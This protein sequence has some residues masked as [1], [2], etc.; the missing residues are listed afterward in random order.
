MIKIKVHFRENVYE[1]TCVDK[2]ELDTVLDYC[3]RCNDF[4]KL[5]IAYEDGNVE[6]IVNNDFV[7]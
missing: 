4:E 1:D 7:R 6:T 2:A 3:A 5:E